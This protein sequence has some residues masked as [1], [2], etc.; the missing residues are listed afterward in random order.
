MT[1]LWMLAI[2]AAVVGAVFGSF[3]NVVI[4]RIPRDGSIFT[5]SRS[6]CPNC[7]KPIAWYDNL[8]I[9]SYLFLRGKCRRCKVKISPRYL[10]VEIA[11]AGLWLLLALRLGLVAALPAFLVMTTVLVILSAIDLEHRRLPNRILGPAA[12]IAIALLVL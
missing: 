12:L 3:S 10:L 2:V 5:P 11:V 1:E 4:Y 7:Q 6:F 9:L 8:P